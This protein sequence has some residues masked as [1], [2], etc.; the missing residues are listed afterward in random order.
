MRKSDYRIALVSN[1]S[2]SIYN[3]RLEV[4]RHLKGLG[5]TIYVIAPRDKHSEKLISEGFYFIDAPVKSYSDNP[6]DD[7]RYFFFLLKI[8]RKN[9]FHHIFHYTIKSNIYGS[10]AARRLGINSTAVVTGLGRLLSLKKGLKKNIIRMLYKMACTAS[11]HIWFLNRD[12]LDHF[13]NNYSID[14]SKVNLLPSEGVNLQKY[15]PLKAKNW[16]VITFLFAGRL[17]L[18]KGILHFLK[19]AEKVKSY[20]PDVHFEVLGFLD[21]QDDNSL[22]QKTILDYQ[23]RNIITFH[24]DTEEVKPYLEGSSCVVLPSYYGEGVSKILLEAAAMS[25][26]IITA[27]N[28]GCAEVVID[29]FNGFLC[30]CHDTDSLVQQLLAFISLDNEAKEIMGKN[31]RKHVIDKYDVKKIKAFYED[32]LGL[33]MDQSEDLIIKTKDEVIT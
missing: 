8:Y 7:I 15:T 14:E 18:E 6:L 3:F 31:G 21:P 33:G 17:L 24:G 26:P 12:D 4:A 1:T 27:R 28:R 2:W 16:E 22:N 19:A 20:Y 25:T 10:F 29:G 13:I 32:H 30:D 5:A 9:R 11:R 23:E